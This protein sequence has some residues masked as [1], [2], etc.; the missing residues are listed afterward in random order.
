MRHL[1]FP[2]PLLALLFPLLVLG[3]PARAD[4]E[5]PPARAEPTAV[6]LVLCLDTSGSMEG[7]IDGARRKLWSVVSELATAKPTPRLRVALLTYG[8]PGDAEAGFVVLQTDLTEDLDLVSEKLFALTTNGGDEYV[9]RVLSNA[10][11][12]LA[13]AEP[14][15]L[16]IAFVAGNESAD[17]DRVKSFRDEA[18]RAV[19]RGVVVNAIYCGGADDGD[20]AGWRELA[21]LGR[22]RFAHIDHDHGTVAIATPYDEKLGRLST[23]LNK[24]YVAYGDRA[25]EARAR[26]VAQDANAEGAGAPAAAERAAAKAGRLY[27]N[28]AWD[29][30]D[31]MKEEDFDLEKVAEK[32]LP[33]AM[34]KMTLEQRRAHLEQRRQEREKIQAEIQDLDAKRR[35]FVAEEQKRLQLDDSRGLDRALRE[36]IREQ[37]AQR[38]LEFDK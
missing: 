13:W 31:R 27:D 19:T 34:Q 24:T 11:D 18:A 37:G 38:G 33:E 28:G 17:Q 32:D 10:L 5:A 30:V 16:R 26:Q 21:S 35:A 14:E 29:L 1:A 20:A 6:D 22:G 8:S 3:L 2:L 7:L 9:G 25:E 4:E 23:A 15:G 12:R 36:A